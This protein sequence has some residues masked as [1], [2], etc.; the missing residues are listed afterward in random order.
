MLSVGNQNNAGLTEESPFTYEADDGPLTL[1]D[2]GHI[3]ELANPILPK[4]KLLGTHSILDTLPNDCSE[5]K[6]PAVISG[7]RSQTDPQRLGV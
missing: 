4:G 6:E 3:R 7:T 5:S 2:I 1:E